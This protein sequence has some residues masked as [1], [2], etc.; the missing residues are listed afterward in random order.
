MSSELSVTQILANLEA[1]MAFHRDKEKHHAEQ[2][3]LHGEQRAV[4]AA[5]LE[6]VTKHYEAFRA[7]AGEAV[8]R[9]A[10]NVIPAPAP[11]PRVEPPQPPL[12]PTLP[13][14]LVARLVKVLPAGEELAPSRVAREV[15]RRYA[16]ELRKPMDSRLA[17]AALRRLMADGTLQLVRKGTAHHEAVYMRR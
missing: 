8:E 10:R 11:P 17:S 9:V 16:A 13:S 1:Q 2:E 4:H 7:A 12:K 5:E 14:R 6:T 15:N 3:A